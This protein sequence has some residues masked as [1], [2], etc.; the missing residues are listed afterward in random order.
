MQ[1][2][3]CD[4]LL[5]MVQAFTRDTS[6]DHKASPTQWLK[7]LVTNNIQCLRHVDDLTQRVLIDF[8]LSNARQFYSSMGSNLGMKGLKA[9]N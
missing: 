8:T 7:G 6:L 9:N 4:E 5:T 1:V 3:S 2:G